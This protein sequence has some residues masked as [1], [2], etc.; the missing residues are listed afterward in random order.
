MG[1]GV[2]GQHAASSTT[3]RPPIPTGSPWSERKRYVW[4]DAEQGEWTGVGDHPDFVPDRPPDYDPPEG[5]EGMDALA[6]IDAVHRPP[7]RPRLA[8]GADAGWSTGRCRPTTSRRS[9]RSTT[10]STRCART[11]RGSC[12]T[13]PRT[14]TTQPR[15]GR[16]SV[17][18]HD[19][20]AD[21]APH[22]GRH[23]A[24]AC[25]ISSELQPEP[26]V[27][28]SPELAAERG[29]EHA[30]WATVVTTRTAIEARVMVTDRI[31]PLT[32]RG[33]VVHQ[34]GLPYHWGRMG[35][36]TGD[37]ANELLS[38]AL[39]HN[40]HISEYKVLTCDVVPGRRPRGPALRRS[41]RTTAAC[42][43]S[44][45]SRRDSC[46]MTAPR[47]ARASSPTRRCASAARRARSP[48]RSGTTSRRRT[49]ASPATPTTTRST[50]APTPGATS[51]SSSSASRSTR[52]RVAGRQWRSAQQ[53]AEDWGLQTYQDGDGMRW[54]MASDVCKHC[55]EAACLEVCPT[56]ALFRTEF[57][58]VVVQPDICN[59]CGYCVPA[60]PF[61]VLDRREDDGRVWKC[62]LCYDRL[63]DDME[64][65]CAQAC[66][67]D[68]IQF[69]E[70][71]DL[72][73]RADGAAASGCTTRAPSRR[74]CTAPI[75]TTASAASARSSCCSTSPRSTACRPIRDDD[76][77]P[78]RDVGR[79][80]R[81]AA[82]RSRCGGAPRG[83]RL[84]C[85]AGWPS[86]APPRPIIKRRCGRG[87][88]PSTSTS[89]GW[90]APRPGSS[91]LAEAARERRAR[92]A[93][94]GGR[95]R[96]RGRQ[97]GAAD[98]RPRAARALPAHAA[99]VQGHV[100]DERR[101]V[102]AGRL[103]R[104]TRR[105]RPTTPL[106]GRLPG[107]RAA[108]TAAALLGLPLASYT[109]ALV[110]NTAVPGLARV[111]PHAP[112]RVRQRRGG[113]RG[114]RADRADAAGRPPAPRAG[115]RSRARWRRSWRRR[116]W[117]AGSASCRT[118][119]GAG[120]SVGRT[121]GVRGRRGDRGRGRPALTRCR[122]GRRPAAQLRRSAHPLERVQG[123]LRVGA[124]PAP[125]GRAAARAARPALATQP[126]G[127]GIGWA[128]SAVATASRFCAAVWPVVFDHAVSS[129][130]R[131]S[132]SPGPRTLVPVRPAL[133]GDRVA[134][135]DQRAGH[136]RDAVVRRR[137]RCRSRPHPPPC[138]KRSDGRRP[139]SRKAARPSARAPAWRC[140][141]AA[142]A[143]SAWR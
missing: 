122:R 90:P 13:G 135:I 142:R 2:A 118:P 108:R 106:G 80:R 102:G 28:V 73:E 121:R 139:W 7:R 88:S 68:S 111:A 70:L 66:P 81:A 110:A 120:F 12:S 5:A 138:R 49:R 112:V 48:A 26:F 44:D 27:E 126:A 57:D 25:R 6:R 61:G 103:R 46:G 134:E 86:R 140:S 38:L 72:R 128:A 94:V 127:A 43:V 107:G 3:A 55:T 4:W 45:V 83:R 60:C 101:L 129:E 115:S 37:S 39:D 15:L 116:R 113:E 100:A 130:L 22:G 64:P 56:G 78:R 117:S 30:G 10:R 93:G 65:A 104:A 141:M 143:R 11:R 84:G 9:R 16:L 36:V 75:P 18:A 24:D 35:L 89:A 33:R 53:A 136:L 96:G 40:V 105:A 42:V 99:D 14:R 119:T 109:A 23:V 8:V 137:P 41:S 34:V 125:H 21:R 87:R 133:A 114:R 74:S 82:R 77:R 59:G 63:K 58:T 62:T 91:R 97:P 32:V 79:R 95:A 52:R 17:R 20:P 123:R 19:L 1:L 47:R 51:R 85:G 92:P 98:L 29:L 50:S 54:L 124:Q 76:A 67:T 132:S 71:D 31:R 69:G 131:Y